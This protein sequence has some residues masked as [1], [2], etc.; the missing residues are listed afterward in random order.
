MIDGLS[1]LSVAWS[2]KIQIF[3]RAFNQYYHELFV[4]G[5]K[6]VNSDDLAK[7]I[8]QEVF[9]ALWNNLDNIATEQEILPFLY[10]TLRNNVLMHYRKSEVHLKY[11]IDAVNQHTTGKSSEDILL[12]KEL[13]EVL[14]EEVNKM[15]ARMQA[16]YRRKKE[17]NQSIKEIADELGI[18]E[19]TVK[20]QLQNAYTRLRS[21]LTDYNSPVILVGFVISHM[22][23]LLHH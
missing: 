13:E 16:I 4:T 17:S 12:N 10:G 18:S 14:V 9:I 7:D 8:L 5:V 1:K 2:T 23:V 22:P 15:P 20:N 19:Q 6:K 11:A 21:R 3:E